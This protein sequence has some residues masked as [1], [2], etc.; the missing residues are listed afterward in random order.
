VVFPHEDVNPWH[1]LPQFT[2]MEQNLKPIINKKL[3]KG[4]ETCN[5]HIRGEIDRMNDWKAIARL[6]VFRE[7]KHKKEKLAHRKATGMG[8]DKTD[9]PGLIGLYTTLNA[10]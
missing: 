4:F 9:Q 3:I 1:G 7:K 10:N 8:D 2:I 5:D 6:K